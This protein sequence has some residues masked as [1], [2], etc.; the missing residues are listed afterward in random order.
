MQKQVVREA[1]DEREELAN[2]EGITTEGHPDTELLCQAFFIEVREQFEWLDERFEPYE[3]IAAI[4]E[5]QALD[6]IPLAEGLSI[7][8]RAKCAARAQELR[9]YRVQR[10]GEDYR[11][12]PEVLKGRIRKKQSGSQE[13]DSTTDGED[14]EGDQ[15]GWPDRLGKSL[16]ATPNR[17]ILL[18]TI[19]PVTPM[20]RRPVRMVMTRRKTS[21]MPK[22]R[23]TVTTKLPLT[24]SQ[25]WPGQ[26]MTELSGKI[27]A[28]DGEFSH[29]MRPPT[30]FF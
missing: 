18:R 7:L 1:L 8:K 9:G 23:L 19:A 24:S 3:D 5:M 20:T 30:H 10:I 22:T 6:G 29:S 28:K 4:E 26:S 14:S 13:D 15:G 25:C 2:Q 21:T 27:L 16:K 17:D 11:L 12:I